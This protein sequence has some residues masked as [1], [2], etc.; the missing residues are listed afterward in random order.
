MKS[1]YVDSWLSVMRQ[2]E[3]ETNG[4]SADLATMA[5]HDLRNLKAVTRQT[6]DFAPAMF[7]LV[8]PKDH[9]KLRRAIA[10]LTDLRERQQVAF[11]QQEQELKNELS[12]L[13]EE[14]KRNG[15]YN[16]Q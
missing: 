4:F 16:V 14:I 12:F 15:G 8:A 13:K 6:I 7:P 11:A 9:P 3:V 10:Y 2:H 1:H 5:A